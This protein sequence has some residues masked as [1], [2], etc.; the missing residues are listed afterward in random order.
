MLKILVKSAVIMNKSR[1]THV[2]NKTIGKGKTFNQN[3]KVQTKVYGK[4]KTF[5]QNLKV[6]NKVYGKGKTFNQNLKVQTK[7][8]GKGKKNGN[9]SITSKII[10]H[11]SSI[12]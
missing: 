7:I 9:G 4:G 11:N 10:K 2:A 12:D 5:N 6:Q 8:Y 1:A 3:L